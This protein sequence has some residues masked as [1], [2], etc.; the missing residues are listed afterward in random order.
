MATFFLRTEILA[1]LR[2]SPMTAEDLAVYLRADPART[3]LELEALFL[4][5]K[6]ECARDR[7]PLYRL[8]Q[9]LPIDHGESLAR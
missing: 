2:Q 6:V 7:G 4:S 5:S 9:S 8:A 3:E 1:A